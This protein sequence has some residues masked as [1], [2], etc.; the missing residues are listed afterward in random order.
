M[1]TTFLVFILIQIHDYKL[2]ITCQYVNIFNCSVIKLWE[3]RKCMQKA[4]F[5]M[6]TCFWLSSLRRVMYNLLP[7]FIS[8]PGSSDSCLRHASQIP[9]HWDQW[10]LDLRHP[11]GQV[12]AKSSQICP[13]PQNQLLGSVAI[14]VGDD[15]AKATNDREGLR[16]AVK[17]TIG[18]RPIMRCLLLPP[19]WSSKSSRSHK[20]I[21][22]QS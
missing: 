21:R 22:H 3:F 17:L 7:S 11:S 5:K 12:C 2:L 14:K 16:I 6:L 1:E 10:V 18:D 8:N 19:P 20:E 9:P 15:I 4:S 13:G